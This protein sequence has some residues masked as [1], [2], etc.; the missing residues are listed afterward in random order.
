MSRHF[1]KFSLNTY[2]NTEYFQ[3]HL[4]PDYP[5]SLVLQECMAFRRLPANLRKLAT[6]SKKWAQLN[7]R[8]PPDDIDQWYDSKGN[9]LDPDTGRKLT[10]AEIDA[11]WG[12]PPQAAPGSVPD[13][14]DNEFADP[15][16][17]QPSQ[18]VPEPMRRPSDARLKRDILSHGPER[19]SREYGIPI[20]HL[21]KVKRRA[22]A[23]GTTVEERAQEPYSIEWFADAIRRLPDDKEVPEGQCGYNK[24]T[25]QKDH[26]LGWLDPKSGTGTYPRSN[27]PGRDACDVYNRIVE[28]MMLLWLIS[29]AGVEGKLVWEAVAAV[30][31]TDKASSLQSKSKAIRS[32]VPW[33]VVASALSKYEPAK[34]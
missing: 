30:L 25:R 21:P 32:N 26:W 14:P 1:S 13:L 9:E 28:P 6:L 33:S 31:N 3:A 2:L 34:F 5:L 12:Y 20:D 19:V 29:A 15:A 24:Y 23:S 4:P 7:R 22:P 18:E 8:K 11:E 16:T 17:W 27:A 10:D